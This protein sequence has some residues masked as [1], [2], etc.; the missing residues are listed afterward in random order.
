M[1]GRFDPAKIP[2][3]PGSSGWYKLTETETVNGYGIYAEGTDRLYIANNLIGKCRSAGYFA[4]PVSFRMHGTE[5]GG[6]SRDNHFINNI[7][8]DCKEAAIKMPTKDNVSEGNLFV[9]MQGGYL[10]V[11]YPQPEVCLH[12][13]AW[14]EFMGFDLTGQDGWFDISVDTEKYEV[15]FSLL[16]KHPRCFGDIEKYRQYVYNPVE[17]KKV[18]KDALIQTDFFGKEVESEV[19]I[20]GPFQ[21]MGTEITYMIDPRKD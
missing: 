20:P 10:R 17:V 14:Q 7:F 2:A 13:P 21:S 3:E 11:I 12:L 5:R 16:D 8:Y 4:K 15:S 9:K 19:C 1:E 6:T 18:K